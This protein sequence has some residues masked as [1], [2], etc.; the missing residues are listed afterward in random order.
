MS[1]TRVHSEQIPCWGHPGA[2]IALAAIVALSGCVEEERDRDPTSARAASGDATATVQQAIVTSFGPGPSPQTVDEGEQIEI[3]IR[4]LCVDTNTDPDVDIEM[5]WQDGSPVESRTLAVGAQDTGGVVCGPGQYVVCDE[6]GTLSEDPGCQDWNHTYADNGAGTGPLGGGLWEPVMAAAHDGNTSSQTVE[7]YVENLPPNILGL[8]RTG[9]QLE[10]IDGAFELEVEDPGLLDTEIASVVWTWTPTAQVADPTSITCDCSAAP[11]CDDGSNLDIC[12]EEDAPESD[13]RNKIYLDDGNYTLTVEVTDK[14]GATT[15]GTVNTAINN[16]VPSNLNILIAG[17]P[18]SVDSG[19]PTVLTEGQTYTVVGLAEEKGIDQLDFDWDFGDTTTLS[20]TGEVTKALYP[21]ITSFNPATILQ[22]QHTWDSTGP[23]DDYTVDFMVSDDDGGSVD[24]QVY[25]RIEDVDPSITG[26]TANGSNVDPTV[27][28]GGLVRFEVAAE[29]GADNPGFDDLL[30]DAY[31]WRMD[32]APVAPIADLVEISAGCTDSDNFCELRFLDADTTATYEVDVVVEDEDSTTDSSVFD[33]TVENVEPSINQATV[34]PGTISEASSASIVVSFDDPADTLD[35]SYELSIDWGDGANDTASLAGTG[36]FPA[37]AH[38][39]ADNKDCGGNPGVCTI[40]VQVCETGGTLCSGVVSRNITVLNAAPSPFIA[41]TGPFIEGVYF[42]LDGS[43]M[44]PGAANDELY[45]WVWTGM[46]NDGAAELEGTASYATRTTD[47]DV[48]AGAMI[49]GYF[50]DV[51]AAGLTGAPI[52]LSITDVDNASSDR[53]VNVNVR[54]NVP[55][56]DNIAQAWVPAGDSDE[57]ATPELTIDVSAETDA[58]LL[59]RIRVDWGDGTN[60]TDTSIAGTGAGGATVTLT[61]AAPYADSGTYTISVALDDEDSTATDQF[62]VTVD[63]VAPTISLVETTPVSPVIVTEGQNVSVRITGTDPSQPDAN[64][65]QFEVDWGDGN[66]DFANGASTGNANEARTRFTH[67]YTDPSPSYTV[68][69]TLRDKDGGEDTQTLDI[70]VLN[71][72]P[73]ITDVFNTGP[74]E[75]NT[76]VTAVMLVDNPGSDTLAYNFNFAC[77]KTDPA[78]VADA[79]FTD[80][81]GTGGSSAVASNTYPQD[82]DYSVCVRVCDDD[83]PNF[84]CAYG[85]TEITINN[86]APQITSLPTPPAVDEDAAGVD[87][88]INPTA[89][90]VGPNDTLTY[91]IDCDSDGADDTS[92]ASGPFTC[93]YTDSGMYTATVTVEDGDGGTAREITTVRVRNLAP[94]VSALAG[95]DVDEGNATTLTAS[96]TDAGGDDVTYEWD[97][98]GDGVYDATTSTGSLQRVYPT[99]GDKTV[100]LRVCDAEGACD[101]DTTTLMVGNVAPVLSN[102]SVPST[103]S[104]GSSLTVVA[105][106]TDAGGDDLTYTFTFRDSANSTL[107]VVGPQASNVASAS[108]DQTGTY[109]VEVE[110]TDEANAPNTPASDTASQSF[111]ITDVN[112]VVNA[113]AN[114][115][116]IPEGG[117]TTVT[118]NSQGTSP[119]LVS[120]D[121]NGDGDFDD[122]ED[123]TPADPSD[124]CDPCTE[125]LTYADNR[126][127]DLPYRVLVQVTDAD[128]AVASAIVSITVRNQAPSLDPVSDATISEDDTLSVTLTATDPGADDTISYELVNGPAG[129][130]VAATSGQVTWSPTWENEGVNPIVVR[131]VDDDGAASEQTFNVTVTIV[132]TNNNGLSDNRERDLN[133]GQ[134]LPPDADQID[135]DNDGVS[136]LDEILA[137]TDP[138]ESDAP[139]AP[140]PLSPMDEV[141]DVLRPTLTV[142]N[143]DSPRED[144]LTYTFVVLDDQ[145]TE[146][147]RIADVDEGS[148]TTSVDVDVDL[149]EDATYTWYAFASDSVADGPDSE[150]AEFVVNAD[151][152]AP[153]APENLLPS[154]GITLP[155][156]ALAALELR[157]VLDPDGD[158]VVYVFQVATSDTFDAGDI[159]LESNPRQVPFLAL[160]EPLDSGTYY[161]R[162]LAS[163]GVNDSDYSD[164]TSF[165]IDEAMAA[166]LPPEAPAIVGPYGELEEGTEE[167]TLTIEAASDPDGDTLEY[168]FEIATNSAFAGADSSG[169]QSE[170]TFEVSG[171]EDG[172]TYHWRAR[173]FD[174]QLSSPWMATEFTIAIAEVE[175]PEPPST[176][177]YGL[178][179]LNPSNGALLNGPPPAFTWSNAT[180]EDGDELSYTLVVSN[181]E[182][183]IDPFINEDVDADQGVSSWEPGDDYIFAEGQTFYWS[184]TATDDDGNE[185]TA[186]GIFTVYAP[187]ETGGTNTPED[188]GCGCRTVKQDA[189]STPQLALLG[190]ALMGLVG[191]RRRRQRRG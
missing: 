136:D 102:V 184:V 156:G 166:N 118:V 128:G 37:Q 41:T 29:S 144:D 78:T 147:T 31:T 90:D 178:A 18:V 45:Q 55:S 54:D 62:D 17:T 117:T 141:V 145:G 111:S 19:N 82:G 39:Y 51:P 174:G 161:W 9:A 127:G 187:P 95:T 189:S 60:A 143:A 110:V 48:A 74:V 70:E 13:T 123:I 64:N 99:D 69:I 50:E 46:D 2:A 163:D 100:G 165:V 177:P 138:Q 53:V 35:G 3:D 67:T 5:D 72:A 120:Y 182:D 155:Q 172:V 154:D 134:L 168:E 84:G 76:E 116:S 159:V 146:V 142:V 133:N 139:S 15:T 63:N 106:A 157:A 179:L 25:V 21:S 124:T 91:A 122:A 180:D 190:L 71:R 158:D 40:E 77:T 86:V 121:V 115:P 183:L 181:N 150:E 185:D 30:T 191:L 137:G 152:V 114:P 170:L 112:V 98:N 6:T 132:D 75:E 104:K 61:K 131:A 23:S 12:E 94:E 14:D 24:N 34:S 89:T 42:P 129:V 164:A 27:N 93:T 66:V 28:E 10:G 103:V 130:S 16:Q 140:L 33:V 56:I 4:V 101:T 88:A 32:G 52:Q 125:T 160:G 43:F 38:T 151:N 7:V 20:G 47:V 85:L 80:P 108:I 148:T 167:A 169:L 87:V 83:G 68:T 153:P 49:G 126:T 11:N 81:V 119:Y 26:F 173:A 186:T 135:T 57:P 176:E 96:A 58:D 188:D 149:T 8:T 113:V 109:S 92:G 1:K 79:D 22:P 105:E 171:L 162:G 65:L 36:T 97:L 175:E 44:D 107:F 59:S 73:T